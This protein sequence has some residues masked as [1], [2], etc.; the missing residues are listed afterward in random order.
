MLGKF[1]PKNKKSFF[2]VRFKNNSKKWCQSCSKSVSDITLEYK[3]P[4][5]HLINDLLYALDLW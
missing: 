4:D 5:K 2:T 3:R 1:L